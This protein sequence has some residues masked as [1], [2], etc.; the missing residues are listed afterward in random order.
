MK[1]LAATNTT[2]NT[3]D[4]AIRQPEI[5]QFNARAI[6]MLPVAEEDVAT[7]SAISPKLRNLPPTDRRW[8]RHIAKM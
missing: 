5:D 6:P 4:A 8:L 2:Q 3:A 7:V 1:K